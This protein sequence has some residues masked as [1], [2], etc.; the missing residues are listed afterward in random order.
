[1]QMVNFYHVSRLSKK[2]K[3]KI[4]KKNKERKEKPV[5]VSLAYDIDIP[6]NLL[7]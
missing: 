2:Y 6:L 5:Y 4:I 7:G 3:L 1:M